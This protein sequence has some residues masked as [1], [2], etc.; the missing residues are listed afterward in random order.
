MSSSSLLISEALMDSIREGKFMN[1]SEGK[2]SSVALIHPSLAARWREELDV[3]INNPNFDPAP[4]LALHRII[5]DS[6]VDYDEVCVLSDD[7]YMEHERLKYEAG[8]SQ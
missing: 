2:V 1:S 8:D 3:P 5:E 6:S 7:D 4:T